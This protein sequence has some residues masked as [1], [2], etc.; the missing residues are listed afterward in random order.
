[1]APINEGACWSLTFYPHLLLLSN[2]ELNSK[3]SLK[4][5]VNTPKEWGI[6]KISIRPR[7]REGLLFLGIQ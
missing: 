2:R 5:R 1:M 6:L 7:P 4:S 3:V